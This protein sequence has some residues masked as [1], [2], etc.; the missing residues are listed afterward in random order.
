MNNN[1]NTF[2]NSILKY[3]ESIF[4]EYIS[5]R[6]KLIENI[7]NLQLNNLDNNQL[8]NLISDLKV[9]IDP[10]KTSIM[11]I[12]DHFLNTSLD[13]N[14]SIQNECDLNNL[15]KLYVLLDFLGT[16]SSVSESSTE[17]ETSLELVTD[18]E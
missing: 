16:G 10:I 6:S 7:K 15:M 2:K 9:I 17:S 14:K 8:L 11:N 4:N 12:D 1:T 3:E 13:N 18:S 5:K